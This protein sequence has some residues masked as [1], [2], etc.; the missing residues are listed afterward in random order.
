MFKIVRVSSDTPAYLKLYLSH[1]FRYNSY[2]KY[3][4]NYR[5]FPGIQLNVVIA[6]P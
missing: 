5:V 4:L 2:E 3:K 1:F 6:K